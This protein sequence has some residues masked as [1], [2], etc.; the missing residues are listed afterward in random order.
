MPTPQARKYARLSAKEVGRIEF[1]IDEFGV[2]HQSTSKKPNDEFIPM[3]D[4]VQDA[5]EDILK[6]KKNQ[7]SD[8]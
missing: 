5:I 8:Q 1:Q 4:R 3:P 2:P 7:D 6:Q